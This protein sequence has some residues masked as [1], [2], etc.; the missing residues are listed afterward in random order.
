MTQGNAIPD[1]NRAKEF[2][3]AQQDPAWLAWLADM[4]AV[5]T[6]FVSTEFSGAD[7]DPFTS[8]GL[9]L[10]EARALDRWANIAEFKDPSNADLADKYIRYL[11]EVFVRNFGARWVN[12]MYP[13]DGR[14]IASGDRAP[15]KS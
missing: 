14:L 8:E 9:I 7:I 5:V 15:A 10:A 1:R 12:I 11:G 2:L 6:Q 3:A 13:T 4:D